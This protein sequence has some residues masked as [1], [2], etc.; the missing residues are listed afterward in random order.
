[1]IIINGSLVRAVSN[2]VEAYLETYLK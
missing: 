1:M 2:D